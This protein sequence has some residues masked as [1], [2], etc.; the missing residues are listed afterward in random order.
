MEPDDMKIYDEAH[1]K[2]KSQVRCE[3]LYPV[4]RFSLLELALGKYASPLRFM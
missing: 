2:G 1:R 4:C 3:S